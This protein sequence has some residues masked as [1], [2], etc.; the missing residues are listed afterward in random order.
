VTRQTEQTVFCGIDTVAIGG[1][2]TTP[3]ICAGL[4]KRGANGVQTYKSSRGGIRLYVT[5][6]SGVSTF[7][8][9]F[10]LPRLLT[11]GNFSTICA[12]QIEHAVALFVREAR[13]LFPELSTFDLSELPLRR[14]DMAFDFP[15]PATPLLIHAMRDCYLGGHNAPGFVYYGS[16]SESFYS[17]DTRGKRPPSYRSLIC[18]AKCFLSSGEKGLRI[19]TRFHSEFIKKN[20][21]QGFSISQISKNFREFQDAGWKYIQDRFRFFA[22]HDDVS[23]EAA[24]ARATERQKDFLRCFGF[25]SREVPLKKIEAL[26]KRVGIWNIQAIRKYGVGYGDLSVP[27]FRAF[28]EVRG[29]RR[30]HF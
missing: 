13:R 11:G 30:L 21:G 29:A 28:A 12:E 14:L 15:V 10:A 8:L 17:K 18:Y 27:E 6:Y 9:Q 20:F 22:P 25:L 1:V 24:I 4:L 5:V 16:N 23:L 3:I 7:R 26:F 19:E 2:A